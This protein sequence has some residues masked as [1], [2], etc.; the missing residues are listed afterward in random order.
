MDIRLPSDG[1]LAYSRAQAWQEA[2]L[3]LQQ[4]S[5]HSLARETVGSAGGASAAAET[6]ECQTCKN[7]K[8]QDGSNDPTVSFQTPTS[9][10]PEAA[11]TAVRAHEQEHV[12]HEQVNARSQGRRVVSQQVAI[13]YAICPDCGRSYVS[14]GTTTTVTKPTDTGGYGRTAKSGSGMGMLLDTRM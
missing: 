8:Y 12:A 4:G 6:K 14:G 2:P 9:L 13:H 7:R 1:L 11:E 10:S 5:Q 3:R